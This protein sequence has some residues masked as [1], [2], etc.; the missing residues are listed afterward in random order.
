MFRIVKTS[1]AARRGVFATPHGE[2]QTPVFMNVGTLAAIKGAVS[3]RDLETVGCQVEL[4][5]TYH[6]HLRPGEEI[7]RDMGGLHGFMN[8]PHPILTDSGGIQEEAP[9]LGKPVLV[10]RDTTERPEGI[11]AGTLK[12]VG[13]N[14]ET[15]YD[16]FKL[17]LTDRNEYEK[18]SR[19]S[20]P[21]GDGH[22]CERIARI[23]EK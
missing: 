4:S 17:L 7:V 9:S 1:G 12:L 2:I 16:M 20:N 22:A 19:A 21:Y 15:I 3:T 18:M 8:W 10:M 11:E 6:L 23:L 5:N 14:E 13:T